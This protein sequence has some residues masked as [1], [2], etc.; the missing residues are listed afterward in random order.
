[1]ELTDKLLERLVKIEGDWWAKAWTRED[2]FI[3]WDIY[4]NEI[5]TVYD[6]LFM[7]E[8]GE[9]RAV[10][11]ALAP[12]LAREVVR[13]RAENELLCNV[14]AVVKAAMESSYPTDTE[15]EEE[16]CQS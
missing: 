12:E 4:C 13:L 8:S 3:V 6:N 16:S 15:S 14:V 11:I 9:D 10:L 1:V 5:A 7:R 2:A